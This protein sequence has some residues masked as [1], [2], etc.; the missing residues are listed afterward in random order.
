MSPVL[1]Q[2]DVVTVLGLYKKV[3]HHPY[4]YEES[5]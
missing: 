3:E 2:H 5:L 4:V 1:I